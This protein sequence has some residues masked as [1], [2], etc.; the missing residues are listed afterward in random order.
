MQKDFLER[1]RRQ[2]LGV[3]AD[4]LKE[5]ENT[6]GDIRAISKEAINATIND[7]LIKAKTLLNDAERKIKKFNKTLLKVRYN[8]CNLLAGSRLK[9]GDLQNIYA[10]VEDSERDFSSAKEEFFEAKILYSYI[11]SIYQKISK[12]KDLP[13]V[14]FETYAGALSDFCGELL[15]KAKLDII[16]KSNCIKGIK[17]YHKDVQTIYQKLAKFSF[18]N[19]S[20]IRRKVENLKNYILRFEELLYDLHQKNND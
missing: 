19:K 8:L 2:S 14:D 11:K 18:S 1:K 17:K 20:G 5:L 12:P 4:L 9:I 3:V 6:G 7:D 15:R 13:L 16:N 10:Q